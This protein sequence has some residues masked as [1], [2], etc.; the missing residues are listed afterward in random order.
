MRS[1]TLYSERALQL[2][3]GAASQELF[4]QE[5][6]FLSEAKKAKCAIYAHRFLSG[7]RPAAGQPSG[8]DAAGRAATGFRQEYGNPNFS[9]QKVRN[10][11]ELNDFL[12]DQWSEF[13]RPARAQRSV[14][15]LY[16][17]LVDC[18]SS[19]LIF[20]PSKVHR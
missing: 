12:N 4:I 20:L 6:A 8:G 3:P 2:D 1:S 7:R 5:K 19:G 10:E 13:E 17:L 16:G 18:I 11:C 9:S 15:I 14:Y